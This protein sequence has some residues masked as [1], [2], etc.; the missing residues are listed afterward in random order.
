M[1]RLIIHIHPCIHIHSRCLCLRHRWYT[2]NKTFR[3]K[4]T[5]KIRF[6]R[7]PAIGIIAGNRKVITLMSRIVPVTGYKLLHNR[8]PNNVVYLHIRIRTKR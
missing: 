1:G 7:N 5:R 6:S 2:S 3:N 4:V 8:R